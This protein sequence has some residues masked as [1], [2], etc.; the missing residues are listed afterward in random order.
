[1]E[2]LTI[3][4]TARKYGLPEFM[5]RSM[6]KRGECPGFFVSSRFYINVP[7]LLDKLDKASMT[8]SAV[9]AQ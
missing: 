8:A 6:V 5:L 7:M 4:Q 3:R 1:M 2:I 9:V